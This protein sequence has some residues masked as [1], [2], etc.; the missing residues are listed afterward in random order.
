MFQFII[1]EADPFLPKFLGHHGSSVVPPVKMVK[2]ALA[3][4]KLSLYPY[5]S[6]ANIYFWQVFQQLDEAPRLNCFMGGPRANCW[7]R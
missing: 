2:F 1:P 4:A 3:L 5:V 7:V 6:P